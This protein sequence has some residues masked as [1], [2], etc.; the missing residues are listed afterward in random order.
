EIYD[1]EPAVL[2]DVFSN[3]PIILCGKYKGKSEGKIKISGKSGRRYIQESFRLKKGKE[4][5]ALRYLWA[6]N[7]IKYLSDYAFYF[8]EPGMYKT[9]SP[10]R[11]QKIID[12]GLKY[13]LLTNFTSFVAVDT[14]ARKETT[15]SQSGNEKSIP[16]QHEY[17]PTNIKIRGYA[18][19]NIYGNTIG[20]SGMSVGLDELVVV[21]Y[22]TVTKKEVLS[23]IASVSENDLLLS[24][25]FPGHSLRNM[26][27]GVDILRGDNVFGGISHFSVNGQNSI[28]RSSY[29]AIMLNNVGIEQSIF[30]DNY[31]INSNYHNNILPIDPLFI[32][33]INIAKSSFAHYAQENADNGVVSVN[34]TRS[35]NSKYIL[36]NTSYSFDKVGNLPDGISN[37][38]K[39]LLQNGFTLKN[40]FMASY[41]KSKWSFNMMASNT[42]QK[43]FVPGMFSNT[44]NL[45][46]NGRFDISENIKAKA[47]LFWINQHI[48]SL[49][50]YAAN[51]GLLYSMMNATP[52]Q[53]GL[54]IKNSLSDYNQNILIPS[55][56]LDYNIAGNGAFQ[57]KYFA[58][59]NL[60]NAERN[61]QFKPGYLPYSEGSSFFVKN[62][63]QSI[64]HRPGFYFNNNYS[65]HVIDASVSMNF[66]NIEETHLLNAQYGSET[67]LSDY[68]YKENYN[69]NE[70]STTAGYS[71]RKE[72]LFK[73]AY[74]HIYNETFSDLIN[75]TNQI[76][77]SVGWAYDNSSLFRN[78]DWISRG[79]IAFGY[80]NSESSPPI[81]IDPAMVLA[82]NLSAS[83]VL[84]TSNLYKASYV[85]NLKPE[86]R[87]K[88]TFI[89]SI[90][91]FQDRL[92]L[93][94]E[95]Y[96][97]KT[98]NM[99]VPIDIST[100]LIG[101]DGEIISKG[102]NADVSFNNSVM[103]WRFN[104]RLI[105]SINRSEVQ[106]LSNSQGI[107]L[108][109]IDGVKSYAINN[110]PYGLL[111]TES[112]ESA[113]PNPDWSLS[114]N[115]NLSWRAL[116]FNIIAEW[117]QGGK[118]WNAYNTSVEEASWFKLSQIQLNYSLP[119]NLSTKLKMKTISFY[120]FADNIFTVSKY[121]GVSPDIHFF[122][123]INSI[124]IDYYNMPDIKKIGAGLKI[125]F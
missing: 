73:A 19:P 23:A 102:I 70:F 99:F 22:G 12:L 59:A 58:S 86:K 92:S 39:S 94:V 11:K 29:P 20:L 104:Q 36:F 103:D 24:G 109:G 123:N 121:S 37:D 78:I 56:E 63:L 15:T 43:S 48:N 41:N 60:R 31:L 74:T 16:T 34:I 116:S 101:N 106:N 124:G 35:S 105:Y 79:K 89:H 14:I 1:T 45:G 120:L 65:D 54:F 108:A 4:N 84:F 3:R 5:S 72:W 96:R 85:E 110:Q 47:D 119:R 18:S 68:E 107:V 7:R 69:K 93:N 111:I 27:T 67:Y 77:V 91:F 9:I 55:F 88:F 32:E 114:Y 97:S 30:A 75:G 33:S 26:A 113:N 21:G 10:A 52:D 62:H 25:I 71:F 28:L 90:G 83:D 117:R 80:D 13:N 115:G 66:T 122:G 98:C 42:N 2:H 17:N 40:S 100:Q 125:K 61:E 49:A 50:R 76:S 64:S 8:E 87:Q 44:N 82:E 46:L 53:T 118:L 112:G 51:S 95:L 38:Q 81:F 57:L 6:R